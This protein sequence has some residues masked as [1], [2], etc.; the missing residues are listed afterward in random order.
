VRSI[1]SIASDLIA[2]ISVSR[3]VMGASGRHG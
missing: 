2:E 3:T 1:T